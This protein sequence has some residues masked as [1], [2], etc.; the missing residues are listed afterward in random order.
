MPKSSTHLFMIASLTLAV[1]ACGSNPKE[2]GLSGGAIGAGTGAVVGAVTGM[3][4]LTGVAIGAGV[5]AVT[6]AVT[7]KDQINLGSLS[8]GSG[9]SGSSA[10]RAS[11]D[12]APPQA[13][14]AASPLVEDVQAALGRAGY[15]AGPADGLAGPRTT[16]A[17]T[18]YQR[19]NGLATDGEPS[20]ALL[21]HLLSRKT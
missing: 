1:A 14:L 18:A 5:G 13:T 12:A 11:A 16:T 15:N 17:I 20:A 21:Q 6:G 19:D 7:S 4:V 10:H 9:N 2:R 8:S 3:S